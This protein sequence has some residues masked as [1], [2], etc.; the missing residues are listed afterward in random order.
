[1][2]T[3]ATARMAKS[4]VTEAIQAPTS[5]PSPWRA[6]FYFFVSC[7]RLRVTC[8]KVPILSKGRK[9][10][11][12]G[13]SPCCSSCLFDTGSQPLSSNHILP[14]LQLI[15]KHPAERCTLVTNTRMTDPTIKKKKNAEN[16]PTHFVKSYLHIDEKGW[17]EG[18]SPIA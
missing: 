8:C 2:T 17:H 15:L 10:Y 4:D 13:V 6:W 7:N 11:I 18:Y 9:H 12:A 16:L 3:S 5:L 14:E 1:M